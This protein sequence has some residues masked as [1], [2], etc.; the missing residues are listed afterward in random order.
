MR[1][2]QHHV[3]LGKSREGGAAAWYRQGFWGFFAKVYFSFRH[4]IAYMENQLTQLTA[5]VQ[6]VQSQGGLESGTGHT[7]GLPSHPSFESYCSAKS[8]TFV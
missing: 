6:A 7:G 4:R 5:W 8:G 1:H 2:Y 3:F